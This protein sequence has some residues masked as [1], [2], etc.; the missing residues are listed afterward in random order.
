MTASSKRGSMLAEVR[1]CTTGGAVSMTR[2]GVRKKEGP[3]CHAVLPSLPWRV[4][5]LISFFLDPI[6]TLRGVD[7]VGTYASCAPAC[8]LVGVARHRRHGD[9]LKRTKSHYCR[10]FL[11][12]RRP[13]KK[14][15][16]GRGAQASLSLRHAGAWPTLFACWWRWL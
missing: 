9:L 14:K 7:A 13:K 1:F 2:R 5:F 11:A 10:T 8:Y 12:T 15:C 6:G 3:A 16:S 4:G